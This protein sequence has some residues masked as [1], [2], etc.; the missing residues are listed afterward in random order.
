VKNNKSNEVFPG[1]HQSEQGLATPTPHPS[2]LARVGHETF[3]EE[4]SSIVS[5]RRMSR[6]TIL[7]T[8]VGLAMATAGTEALL[9]L[10]QGR[11]FAVTATDN[12]V[13]QWNNALLQ[14]IRNMKPGPTI[15][16]RALAVLH[17]C[18]YGA[19]TAYDPIATSPLL[20]GSLRRPKSEQTI[21]NKNTAM[22]Y[23][24]YRAA[25]DLFPT[26]AAVFTS[27]MTTLG[28]DPA[29]TSTDTKTP[30]GIGNFVAQAI[31]MFR[32][33]DGSNQLNNYADTTS[34]TPVNT[35]TSITDPN[36]WQPLSVPTILPDGSNGFVTQQFTTPQWGK[37]IPFSLLSGSQ[38]RP[39]GPILY[40][41]QGYT[42][43]A[44]QILQYSADLNDTTKTIAEYWA[45][46]PHTELP[47]GHWTLLAQFTAAQFISKR[48][49]HDVNQDGKLFFALANALFDASIACWDCKRAYDSIRPVSAVH[50][51]F[52]TTT[53][54]CWGGPGKGTVPMLGGNWAPYQ[55]PTVVTPP[56]P[57][58]VSGHS[59]FSAAGA[60]VLQ[61]FTGSDTFGA[62]YTQS[63]GSSLIEPNLGIPK[64]D[65]TL[66]WPTF[67]AAAVEAGMSRRYGGIH[68]QQGDLDGRTLGQRVGTQAW[69]LA[70]AF[71]NGKASK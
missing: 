68:F 18:M 9:T 26:Q 11:A 62:S 41:N 1:T 17:T 40:P 19:W 35:S 29:N 23:A 38:F 57:E 52:P 25:L 36:R 34:Y 61:Q 71:M 51:L 47:P 27:L 8:G 15:V 66:S 13:L 49:K 5:D 46:G 2:S 21:T 33:N 59:T 53:V 42:D 58:Y 7:R 70:Q 48:D 12:I 50:Y 39:A 6:R 45:D 20:G 24:G 14:A 67:S 69:S 32:H 55:K 65:I 44:N 3:P 54:T 64:T 22:S 28:Y 60:Y 16:A 37:V 31:L 10:Y 56:F 30:A 43:Q 4:L 63:A